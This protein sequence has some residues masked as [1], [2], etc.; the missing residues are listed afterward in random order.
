[1][2]FETLIYLA[3]AYF[4]Q[5]YDLLAP[6]PPDLIRVFVAKEHPETREELRQDL[7]QL[8][9][10][11]PSEEDVRALWLDVAGSSYDPVQHGVSFLDWIRQVREIVAAPS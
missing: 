4:H 11:D 10:T 3:K 8:L 2:P 9:A 1:M 7:D 5:D 6:T